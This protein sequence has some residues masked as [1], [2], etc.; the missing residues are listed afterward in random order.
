MSSFFQTA[1]LTPGNWPLR[2]QRS[3][4][5]PAAVAT[6]MN[7]ILRSLC[8]CVCIVKLWVF[9]CQNLWTCICLWA[10]HYIDL[11]VMSRDGAYHCVRVFVREREW[12]R[13]RERD[14]MVWNRILIISLGKIK[15]CGSEEGSLCKQATHWAM[16]IH[17]HTCTCR[18]P[19]HSV[20]VWGRYTLIN[21]GLPVSLCP[22]GSLATRQRKWHR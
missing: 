5:Q 3:T 18:P 6:V 9:I 4:F 15:I 22:Q 10:S 14:C 20:H 13:Q 16:T 11:R 8:E 12:E 2:G 17:T 7:G 1:L 21:R 19:E